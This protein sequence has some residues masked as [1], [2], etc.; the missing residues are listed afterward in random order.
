MVTFLI[1]LGGS[2]RLS[3]R[4]IAQSAGARVIAADGGIRHAAA[5]GVTPE[6]WVGD[7]DSTSDDALSRYNDVP[8]HAYPAAKALTDGD[9]AIEQALAVGARRIVLAGALG[10]DRTD[11]A[12]SH[13]MR[14][15]ALADSGVDCLL[16][17]GD[18]EAYPLLPGRLALDLP[19]GSLFSVLG[20][21]L[22]TGLTITNARYPLTDFQLDFGASRTIS[23]VAEGAIDI[24]LATGRGLVLARPHDFSGV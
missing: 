18:E 24:S 19:A 3:A 12:L 11:H 20:L 9:I 7:F 6:L 5:L 10:G 15:L 13:M 2:L 22:L 23:N 1:L 17:S 8:R 16:T 4:L 14:A 21:D